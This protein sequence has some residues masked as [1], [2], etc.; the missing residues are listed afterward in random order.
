MVVDALAGVAI[1]DAK[2][3]VVVMSTDDGN[4]NLIMNLLVVMFFIH[5]F[6]NRWFSGNAQSQ[7]AVKNRARAGRD[8]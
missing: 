6:A 4:T 8:P 3:I 1:Q 5:F 7:T 2:T